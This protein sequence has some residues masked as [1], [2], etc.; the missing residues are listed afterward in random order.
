MK[1][2]LI[3]G[4]LTIL[5]ITLNFAFIIVLTT[6]DVRI[7]YRVLFFLW[8]V[9]L[10]AA[11]GLAYLEKTRK[12]RDKIASAIPG[13]P[14][15]SKSQ[16]HLRSSDNKQKDSDIYKSKRIKKTK[17]RLPEDFTTNTTPGFFGGYVKNEDYSNETVQAVYKNDDQLLGYINKK[18]N[19]L[20]QNIELLYNEP[21][22]CWG[23]IFWNESEKIFIAKVYIPVLY[24]ES[25]INRFQKMVQLKIELLNM[26]RAPKD[27]DVY[28]FLEKAENL[29][30]LQQSAITPSS[31]DFSVDPEILPRLSRELLEA[32]Q[33]QELSYLKKYPILISRLEKPHKKEV[34]SSIKKAEKELL[35]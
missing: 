24:S 16:H 5:I 33:W 29:H 13:A 23:N 28:V 17:I 4:F 32:K 19:A 1:R 8:I 31:L 25:E 18:K 10:M 35:A 34:L 20:C 22:V 6:D 30:Y 27:F 2:Y 14:E 12:K 7:N 15:T 26:T 3:Y 11:G 21:L 9:V